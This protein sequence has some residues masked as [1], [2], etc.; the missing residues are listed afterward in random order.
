MS[1]SGPFRVPPWLHPGFPPEHPTKLLNQVALLNTM[2][3]FS[4]L[5]SL[6]FGL[7]AWR[8]GDAIPAVLDASL[9]GMMG[10]M[11]I[12]LRFRKKVAQTAAIAVALGGLFFWLLVLHG[13]VMQS[14]FVWIVVYPAVAL[15]SLGATRGSLAA[16]ILFAGVG[17]IFVA[18]HHHPGIPLYPF[19]V[20]LRALSVYLLAYFFSLIMELTRINF[21][22]RMEATRADLSRHAELLGKTDLEKAALIEQLER[23]LREVRALRGLLPV[24]TDCG[25]L[26]DDEGYWR[27]LG[28]YLQETT[29]TRLTHGVCPDCA[30]EMYAEFGGTVPEPKAPAN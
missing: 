20:I 24:C 10:I 25:K 3:V 30:R 27:E 14:G 6:I 5:F 16:G 12:D 22:A 28:N 17:G 15:F 26:R 21:L 13:S 19:P 11:L 29:G 2:L 4:S 7:L 1:P 23:N 8:R 9:A 18:S